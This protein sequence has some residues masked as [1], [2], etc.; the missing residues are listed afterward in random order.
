MFRNICFL[1][2]GLTI[3]LQIGYSENAKILRYPNTSEKDIVKLQKGYCYSVYNEK[4]QIEDIRLINGQSTDFE[5]QIVNIFREMPDW[6]PAYAEGKP[7]KTY[8]VV[9]FRFTNAEAW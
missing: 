1:L 9:P 5:N 3:S 8:K 6:I 4:G 7:V 2:L